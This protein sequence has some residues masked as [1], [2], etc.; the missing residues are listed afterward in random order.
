MKLQIQKDPDYVGYWTYVDGVIDWQYFT[1]WG[2]KRRL[3]RLKK[4][5]H[6]VSKKEFIWELK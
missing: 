1:L 6:I 2:A 4:K 3:M 5:K